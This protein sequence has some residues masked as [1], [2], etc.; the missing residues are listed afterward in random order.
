ML[1]KLFPLTLLIWPYLIVIPFLFQLDVIV[2]YLPTLLIV[3]LANIIFAC[4]IK[5]ENAAVRLLTWNCRIKLAHIP[6]YC[7]II[8][9][10]FAAPI[11]IP[12]LIVVDVILM[13]ASSMYGINGLIQARKQVYISTKVILLHIAFHF[14]FVLDVIS[15]L[16][17]R[18]KVC[19]QLERS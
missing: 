19:K 8:M 9:L 4:T 10:G 15:A 17:L 11:A 14:V 13:V 3:L 5:G 18:I 7:I 2:Y 6:V 12:L 1:R 16:Y